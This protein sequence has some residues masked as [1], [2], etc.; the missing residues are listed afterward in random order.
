MRMIG[1]LESEPVAR[2]FS[3]Y[4]YVKGI[5]NQ[6]EPESDGTWGIWIHAEDEIEPARHLLR[7]FMANPHDPAVKRATEKVRTLQTQAAEEQSAA[8]ARHFDRD[9]LFSAGG[10]LRSC[11]LTIVL[12]A[13]SVLIYALGQYTP[14][15]AF[16]Q[17]LFI[18]TLPGT[19]LPEI[20]TGQIWR[21]LTPIF[22]HMGPIHLLL[23]M[24][25]M[26]DLGS[27]LEHRLGTLQLG[28]M[29]LG[30][31]IASNVAQYYVSGPAFGGMSGIVYGLLGYVWIRGR[32]DPGCG[33]FLHPTTVAMMLIWLVFGYTNYMPIAN[34]V[35][36]VGLLA[37]ALWGFVAAQRT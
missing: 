9:R 34:T 24:L 30:I 33:L 3:D 18:S 1:H 27:M 29:V 16:L 25:W 17:Y 37:G 12:I 31:G 20:R 13:V 15:G 19:D 6:V 21:L 32:F 5:H 35:H 2:T 28:L 22:I 23:N 11:P 14:L 8:R 26:K 7:S 10:L 36:T 4:L